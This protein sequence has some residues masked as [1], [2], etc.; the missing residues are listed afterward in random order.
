MRLLLKISPA[1]T[2]LLTVGLFVFVVVATDP[3]WR[4]V[5][6]S[7]IGMLLPAGTISWIM[8]RMYQHEQTSTTESESPERGVTSA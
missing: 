3:G 8:W 5:V 1:A 7:V 6:C 4:L 2:V